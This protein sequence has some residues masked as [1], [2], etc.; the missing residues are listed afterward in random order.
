[1]GALL[2]LLGSMMTTSD[3]ADAAVVLALATVA[4]VVVL[5][6]VWNDLALLT[7]GAIGSV[8]TIM[9]AVDSWFPSS[10]A[11]PV[12]L[13]VVGAGLVAT[14]VWVA[15]RRARRGPGLRR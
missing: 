9:V 13:L 5:A 15:H 2:A 4:V 12:A 11:A 10:L 3:R 14:A 6:V 1:M 7:L 8:P